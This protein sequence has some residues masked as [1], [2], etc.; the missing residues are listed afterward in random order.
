MLTAP[1]R[2]KSMV[3][4]KTE[5][6]RDATQGKRKAIPD[7]MDSSGKRRAVG[8]GNVDARLDP[9][10]VKAALAG[11]AVSTYVGEDVSEEAMGM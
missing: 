4:L 9:A 1:P 6:G 10:K 7:E 2:D 3:E 8:E 5:A 11:K